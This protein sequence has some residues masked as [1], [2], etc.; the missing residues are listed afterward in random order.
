MRRHAWLK[1]TLRRISG[2]SDLAKAIRYTL[3]QWGALTTVLRDGRACL[4]NN[5]AE[6]RMRP[7]EELPVRRVARGRQAGH[8]HLPTDQ[9]GG[10]ERLGSGGLS[11]RPARP[12]RRP[13]DQPH[14]RMDL[15]RFC[16]HGYAAY[17]NS[18]G[19]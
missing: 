16:E 19:P 15:P 4:H 5:A 14:R 8:D 13:P 10:D 11:A 3:T 2:K 12:H 1:A 17:T 9:H 6:R 18:R 7:L